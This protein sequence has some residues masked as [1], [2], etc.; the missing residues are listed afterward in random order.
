MTSKEKR[1]RIKDCRAFACQW[2]WFARCLLEHMVT[3]PDEEHSMW[4]MSVL[5]DF[6]RAKEYHDEARNLAKL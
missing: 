5:D 6:I 2:L 3:R 4:M 1:R